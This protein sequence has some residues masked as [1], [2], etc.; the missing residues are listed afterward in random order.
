[1]DIEVSCEQGAKI[2]TNC[3]EAEQAEGR[4]KLTG[5]SNSNRK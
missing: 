4:K 1:M 3:G 2:I 5:P